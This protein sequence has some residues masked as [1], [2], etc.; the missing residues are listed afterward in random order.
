MMEFPLCLRCG[1]I[2]GRVIE[3]NGFPSTYCHR[4]D[5]ELA[6]ESFYRNRTIFEG[7]EDEAILDR[8]YKSMR[9]LFEHGVLPDY[10][11]VLKQREDAKNG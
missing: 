6:V 5:D 2:H 8:L 4:C 7:A 1:Q 9:R 3:H 11:Y 10:W